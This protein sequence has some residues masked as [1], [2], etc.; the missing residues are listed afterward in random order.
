MSAETR[1]NKTFLQD[2][3]K[4]TFNEEDMEV[5]FSDHKKPLYLAAYINQILIKRAL[6]D[7]CTSLNL[8]SLRTLQAVRI[9]K[10]KI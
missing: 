2:T 4:I 3:N 10:G 1:A 7:K 6:V 8:I 9:S 5:G